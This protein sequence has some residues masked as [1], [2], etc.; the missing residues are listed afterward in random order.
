MDTTER[1]IEES[2]IPKSFEFDVGKMLSYI[3]EGKKLSRKP[4]ECDGTAS[5]DPVKELWCIRD[6]ED[7]LS[8]FINDL[9]IADWALSLIAD[10]FV[11]CELGP[12]LEEDCV[13]SCDRDT[14]R[15]AE[16]W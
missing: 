3:R 11:C 15:G 2:P 10:K 13:I 7:A 6:F 12:C 1:Q 14:I 5:S 4:M 9:E 8:S 16:V